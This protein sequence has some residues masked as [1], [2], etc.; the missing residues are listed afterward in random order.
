VRAT[1]AAS[2]HVLTSAAEKRAFAETTGADLVDLE[3][4]A[5]TLAAT[6]LGWRWGIL[7][8]V[9]DA[10]GARL[11]RRVARWVRTNGRARPLAAAGS[12]VIRPWDL[13]PAITLWR[14]ARQAMSAVARR[15]LDTVDAPPPDDLA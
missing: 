7:R 13:P 9:S 14:T 2:P 1:I 12:I 8:G 3:S 4:A 15:L 5:F 6:T 11:P 10:T